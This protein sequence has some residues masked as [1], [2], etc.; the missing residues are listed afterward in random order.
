MRF[1]LAGVGVGIGL[2]WI[3]IAAPL[4]G[5]Q[6]AVGFDTQKLVK[7]HGTVTRV[8][9]INPNTWIHV[10]VKT[11][12]GAMEEWLIEA[13]SAAILVRRGLTKESLSVGTDIVVTA[14]PLKNG[15]P[16]ANGRELTLPDGRTISIRSVRS[17]GKSLTPKLTPGH[18]P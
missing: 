11:L 8:E 17:D 14:Y 3:G 7:L 9:W 12:N 16:R 15:L 5:H 13:G 18:Q 2:F 1:K 4:F 6:N 10:G